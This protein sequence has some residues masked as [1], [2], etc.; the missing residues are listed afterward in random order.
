MAGDGGGVLQLGLD[1]LCQLLAKL[2]T[3]IQTKFPNSNNLLLVNFFQRLSVALNNELVV[4]EVI[5]NWSKI[6]SKLAKKDQGAWH[7]SRKAAVLVY[8]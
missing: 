6:G 4:I 1:R 3:A 5:E 7:L 2:H 8:S